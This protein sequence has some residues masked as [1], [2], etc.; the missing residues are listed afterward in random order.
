[1]CRADAR[2]R[3]FSVT[4][5]Q[6]EEDSVDLDRLA[7]EQIEKGEPDELDGPAFDLDRTLDDEDPDNGR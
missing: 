7:I 5:K 2:H 6:P 3:G 1:M 4:Q